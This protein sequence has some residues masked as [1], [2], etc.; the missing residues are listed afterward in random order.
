MRTPHLSL[1]VASAFNT[2]P[3]CKIDAALVQKRLPDYVVR[4]LRSYL[5]G[6]SIIVGEGR[7]SVTSG[8]PQG[9]VIGPVLWN[10]FYDGL[11]RIAFPPEVEIVCFAYDDDAAIIAT[12]KTTGLLEEAMNDA[13]E[14]VEQWIQAQGLTI[15]SNKSAAIMLTTKRGYA[16]SRFIMSGVEIKLKESIDSDLG[17]ELCSVLGFRKHIEVVSNKAA[18]TAS[19]LARLMP[20]VGGPSPEKRRLLTTVVNFSIVVCSAHLARSAHLPAQ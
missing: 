6:R 1:D 17:V 9:S 19:V 14:M 3:W 10:I 12:G 11:M 7:R 5:D 20:N 4:I 18:K 8:V 16:K 2:A 15:S 13:L